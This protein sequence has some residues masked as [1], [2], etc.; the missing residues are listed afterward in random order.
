MEG[1]YIASIRL[2]FDSIFIVYSEVFVFNFFF[3]F[4]VLVSFILCAVVSLSFAF[5]LI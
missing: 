1:I 5:C 4:V 2:Q 3:R